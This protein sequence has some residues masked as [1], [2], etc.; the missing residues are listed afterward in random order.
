VAVTPLQNRVPTGIHPDT[1]DSRVSD[2]ESIQIFAGHTQDMGGDSPNHS[3]M[4]NDQDLFAIMLPQ[5]RFP[6]VDNPGIKIGQGFGVRRGVIDGIIQI[7]VQAIRVIRAHFCGG[8]AFP[9]TRRIHD[10]G[11][12]LR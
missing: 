3:G 2:L 12:A 4:G 6:T 5:Q 11:L 8:E 9:C 7:I 10:S 1:A